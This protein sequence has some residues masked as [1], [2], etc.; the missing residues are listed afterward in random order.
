MAMVFGRRV[1]WPNGQRGYIEHESR[2]GPWYYAGTSHKIA[3]GKLKDVV[4][5]CKDAGAT[6]EIER[7]YVCLDCFAMTQHKRQCAACGS[8]RVQ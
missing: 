5:A 8:E 3:K 1:T 4:Q 2:F 6:V 7:M